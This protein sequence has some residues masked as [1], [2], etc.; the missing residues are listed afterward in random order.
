M[1]L[2]RLSLCPNSHSSYLLLGSFSAKKY[3][4]ISAHKAKLLQN[5]QGDIETVFHPSSYVKS[6]KRKKSVVGAEK[7]LFDLSRFFDWP[8]NQIGIRQINQRKAN[9]VTYVGKAHKVMKTQ[10]AGR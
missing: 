3:N 7:F 2:S 6:G 9:R 8:N 5:Q 1:T 10:K 4:F